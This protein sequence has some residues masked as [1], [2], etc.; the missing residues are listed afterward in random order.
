MKSYAP[1]EFHATARGKER[2]QIQPD[3]SSEF[4]ELERTTSQL[5][6]DEQRVWA[7]RRAA[8]LGDVQLRRDFAAS[9]PTAARRR[10]RPA[11]TN[12]LGRAA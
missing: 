11:R 8:M 6:S 9:L 2:G 7:W 1:S 10:G 5:K 3:Y 4:S 12:S